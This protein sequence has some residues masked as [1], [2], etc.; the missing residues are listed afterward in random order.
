MPNNQKDVQ[1]KDIHEHVESFKRE[2]IFSN[3]VS[4]DATVRINSSFGDILY[5]QDCMYKILGLW[6]NIKCAHILYVQKY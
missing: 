2:V 4:C 5:K 3:P 6:L 1:F